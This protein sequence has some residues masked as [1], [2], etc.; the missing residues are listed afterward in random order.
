LQVVFAYCNE[1]LFFMNKDNSD[2]DGEML[3]VKQDTEL[4]CQMQSVTMNC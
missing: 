3:H 2:D 1:F 4:T